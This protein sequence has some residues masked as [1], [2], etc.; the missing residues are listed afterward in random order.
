MLGWAGN[1]ACMGK[2][3]NTLNIL[4]GNPKWMVLLRIYRWKNNIKMNLEKY[5]GKT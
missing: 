4:P 3:G 5:N 2:M 1:I